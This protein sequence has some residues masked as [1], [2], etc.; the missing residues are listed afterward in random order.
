[1]SRANFQVTNT[2]RSLL[3]SQNWRTAVV[4][5]LPGYSVGGETEAQLD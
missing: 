2:D 1:M 4:W 3:E 5:G